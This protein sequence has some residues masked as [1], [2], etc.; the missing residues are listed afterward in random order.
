MKRPI[1]L[2][3]GV[4]SSFLRNFL[5]V[6]S[7]FCVSFS[8]FRSVFWSPYVFGPV[9]LSGFGVFVG[10]SLIIATLTKDRHPLPWAGLVAKLGRAQIQ[11]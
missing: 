1:S 2:P 4:L 5:R 6:L 11:P 7:S 10:H 3:F 9:G 8:V